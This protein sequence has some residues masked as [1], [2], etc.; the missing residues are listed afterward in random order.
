M[1]AYAHATLPGNWLIK[2]DELVY[3]VPAI[4]QGWERRRTLA[5]VTLLET[6][7]HVDISQLSGLGRPKNG[8][9][10]L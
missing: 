1:K 10:A 4:P 8:S 5:N 3:L 7:E 2:K 9:A 6:A